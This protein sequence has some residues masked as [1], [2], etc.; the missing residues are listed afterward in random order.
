MH[1]W[2]GVATYTVTTFTQLAQDCSLGVSF[3]YISPT[4]DVAAL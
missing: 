4:M 2:V 1:M 3:H